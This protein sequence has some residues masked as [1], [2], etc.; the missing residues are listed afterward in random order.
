MDNNLQPVEG[1]GLL[2]ALISKL[3]GGVGKLLDR[4]AEYEEEMG[5]LKQITRI[6]LNPEDNPNKEYTL[7]IKLAPVRDKSNMYYVEASTDAP[8]FDVSSIDKKV[9]KLDNTSWKSFDEMINKLIADNNLVQAEIDDADIEDA[10][11]EDVSEEVEDELTDTELNE[12]DKNVDSADIKLKEEPITAR[13]GNDIVE[14]SL[15]LQNDEKRLKCNLFYTAENDEG[16]IVQLK[17]Q[18]AISTVDENGEPLSWTEFYNKI[19]ENIEDYF[20][21]NNLTRLKGSYNTAASTEVDA[22]FIKGST[23][24]EVELV[25][26]NASCD[27]KAA[28]DVVYDIAEVDDFV[29]GLTENPQS[30]HIKETDDGYQID[31]IDEVDTSGTYDK[32]FEA[33]CS[34]LGILSAYRWAI[35]V[36]E[37]YKHSIL[38]SSWSILNMI[39]ETTAKWVLEN[40]DHYAIPC[41][42]LPIENTLQEVKDSSGKLS[43]EVMEKVVS[44]M[45]K[46]FIDTLDG[47]YVNLSHDEQSEV[48]RWMQDLKTAYAYE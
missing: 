37:W 24:N 42:T 44:D 1:A 34:F 16:E 35:G 41:N 8:G 2:S 28:M 23:D 3:F 43:A 14:I 29:N 15:G 18:S 4:A 32:L 12:I 25:A 45:L 47:F 27:I 48:D 17:D 36:N 11:V 21:N 38:D 9:M 33:A 30:Y 20:K 22:T 26:I 39:I 31:E 5:V 46:V 19:E 6:P 40:T 13:W 10:E 7:T